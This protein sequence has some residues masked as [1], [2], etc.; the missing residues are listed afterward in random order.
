[1][2]V[3]VVK[4]VNEKNV[5]R[6]S[7]SPPNPDT[8]PS[9]GR[10]TVPAACPS[11]PKTSTSACAS[12]RYWPTSRLPKSD[13]PSSVSARCGTMV[14]HCAGAGDRTSMAMTRRRGASRSVRK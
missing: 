5:S 14:R 7:R 13:M 2:V 9:P 11:S 10:R 12:L 1:M 6:A 8:L 4:L 3:G